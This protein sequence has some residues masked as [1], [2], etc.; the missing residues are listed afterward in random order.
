MSTG[1]TVE[2]LHD[3]VSQTLGEIDD[4]SALEFGSHHLDVTFDADGV[5]VAV[6][7][8]LAIGDDEGRISDHNRATEQ[9]DRTLDA[10]L[11]AGGGDVVLVGLAVSVAEE[12]GGVAR[13]VADRV[14]A[15]VG[16]SVDDVG[17]GRRRG[18]GI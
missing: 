9:A 3:L 13:E 8:D 4:F 17:D 16:G 1:W 18:G 10:E 15:V 5:P 12:V 2:E 7:F 14:G 11:L 6:E